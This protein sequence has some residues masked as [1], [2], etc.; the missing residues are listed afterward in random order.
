MKNF[1]IP[2]EH[3]N[4]LTLGALA[5]ELPKNV[6]CPGHV[7]FAMNLNLRTLFPWIKTQYITPYTKE[8]FDFYEK[9]YSFFRKQNAPFFKG[10]ELYTKESGTS[11]IIFLF[12]I[13]FLGLTSKQIETLILNHKK[14]HSALWAYTTGLNAD[15]ELIKYFCSKYPGIF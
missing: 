8:T 4:V 2:L 12:A 15:L 10:R 13:F 7:V 5:G 3:R 14:N 9:I 11:C 1:H 6:P